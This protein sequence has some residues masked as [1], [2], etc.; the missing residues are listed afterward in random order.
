MGGEEK[1]GWPLFA[2]FQSMS[3]IDESNHMRANVIE[4]T[5]YKLVFVFLTI[6]AIGGGI[7]PASI[8]AVEA[9]RAI[10][11][12]V[13]R[14]IDSPAAAGSGKPKLGVGPGRRG[15]LSWVETCAS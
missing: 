13:A 4:I 9:T 8:E 12:I 5:T 15:F 3:G 7:S 1:I 6:F 2:L 11:N 14:E 10:E